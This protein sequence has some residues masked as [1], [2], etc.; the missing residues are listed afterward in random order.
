LAES[1]QKLEEAQ[2]IAKIGH[3]NW[4]VKENKLTLSKGI[5]QIL[6]IA[7]NVVFTPEDIADQF[8]PE[9]KH[10]IFDK[11]VAVIKNN[12]G[13]LFEYRIITSKDNLKFIHS[14]LQNPE[15]NEKG[16]VIRLFGIMKD[17]TSLKE[18]EL[19]LEKALKKEQNWGFLNLVLFLLASHEFR[20]P[21]SAILSSAELLGM[22]L[23]SGKTKK[24]GKNIN[25]IKS[26]VSNLT[27]ILNDFLSLEKLEAGKVAV[28]RNKIDLKEFLEELKEEI[29][30]M[31]RP[32]QQLIFNRLVT[33]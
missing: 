8:H 16:E 30:P 22:Y 27:G 29:K 15:F 11:V 26:S 18:S 14:N 4:L 7:D 1:E 10:D 5:Y 17:V 33:L 25:R 13:G 2:A 19:L 24:M 21:L 20:T 28:Q 3:W 32:K 31:L 6:D 12:K 9:D 23:E